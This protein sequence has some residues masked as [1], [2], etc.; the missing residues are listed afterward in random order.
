MAAGNGGKNSPEVFLNSLTHAREGMSGM[1]LLYFMRY[2]AD[3]Y[4]STDSVRWLV[5]NRRIFCVP[6]VNPDG[7]EINWQQYD[8][9]EGYGY[10]RKNARGQQQRWDQ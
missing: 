1:S 8:S 7:Y 3:N 4:A 5:D 6:L 2:L 10:W 9:G